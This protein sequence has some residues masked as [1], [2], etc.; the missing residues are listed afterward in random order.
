MRTVLELVR[1]GIAFDKIIRD[2]HPDLEPEDIR[3]CI[4]YA[5]DVL[6][7]GEAR[8]RLLVVGDMLEL[9]EEAAQWHER[10][11]RQAAEAGIDVV[12]AAGTQAANVAAGARAANA[13]VETVT[14]ADADEAG[15]AIAQLLQDGDV[16]LIKGSRAMGMERVAQCIERQ[17]SKPLRFERPPNQSDA[18]VT[19]R[20]HTP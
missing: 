11:G 13:T 7:A 1:E 9:G 20:C 3:A 16:V 6:A 4:Q 10:V 15:R 18:A 2:Y 19:T 17:Q 12:V 8:R 5:I 14:C